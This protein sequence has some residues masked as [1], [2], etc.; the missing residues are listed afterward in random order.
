MTSP[1]GALL[2]MLALATIAGCGA[3]PAAVTTTPSPDATPSPSAT[4]S[5][6]TPRASAAAA[7]ALPPLS[8]LI[9]PAAGMSE[10]Y[11]LIAGARHTV[12]LTMYELEDTQAEAALAADAAR[13]VD[14]RVI[15]NSSYTQSDNDAAFV[16]LQAHSV[17]V[18]WASS[19]YALT[20]QKTLVI[21]TAVS[22]VMT[23]NWTSRYYYDTR[24]VA[25]IDRSP[26]DIAAI[27]ATFNADYDGAAIT[28]SQ[29]DDLVWSPTTSLDSLLGLIDGATRS[30]Y[31]ENEEMDNSDITDALIAA[32]RRGVDVEVCMTNSS[33]WTAAFRELS[34]A[35]VHVRVY[36]PNAALYIH[37]KVLVRDPGS[38]NQEAFA[39]SQNFSTESLRYNRELGVVIRSTALIGQLA[40]MI[41]GDDA[42][43]AAWNG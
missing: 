16:Y 43:A 32:A 35:G 26:A 40:S 37:A 27:Q 2:A 11:A 4:P 33:S 7:A 6:T 21:D 13:G 15:L 29:G 31:V 25:V 30:L 38:S 22:V 1:R 41:E 24:D 20:H 5:R 34:E 12:D 9:E 8:L 3:A 17:H 14:V 39:G 10:I 19:R 28:P 36:S 18:H 42:G 23:L